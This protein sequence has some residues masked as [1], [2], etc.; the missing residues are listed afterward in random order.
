M[1]TKLFLIAVVIC[2][3]VFF[4]SAISETN[5]RTDTQSILNQHNRFKDINEYTYVRV[6]VNGIWYIYVYDGLILIDIYEE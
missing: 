6:F 3:T 5:L 2:L 1:K 4:Q